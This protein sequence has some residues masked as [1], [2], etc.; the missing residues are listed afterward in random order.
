MV[1]IARKTN[2]AMVDVGQF[3]TM[4]DVE[5]PHQ[6]ETFWTK[7]KK[8]SYCYAPSIV[9]NWTITASRYLERRLR[10]FIHTSP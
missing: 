9:H 8:K 3:P 7:Q 1:G 5:K 6:S 2:D 4:V 10:T